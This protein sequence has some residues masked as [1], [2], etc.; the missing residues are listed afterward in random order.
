MPHATATVN[1]HTVADTDAYELVEGNVYF[2]PSSLNQSFFTSSPTTTK[3]PY[4]GTA[5]YYTI[6]TNK[7]ETKDAAWV[8]AEPKSGY[9]KIRGFVAFYKSKPGVEVV[10]E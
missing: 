2:P 3:C 8:Y 10:S 4:K 9:E 5:T 7:T 1:G 6:T